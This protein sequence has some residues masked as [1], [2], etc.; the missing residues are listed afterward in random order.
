MKTEQQPGLPEQ[1]EPK[2]RRRRALLF[3]GL[4][5][6]VAVVILA[7]LFHRY[8][9]RKVFAILSQIQ[10]GYLLLAWGFG[11][12]AMFTFAHMQTRIFHPLQCGINTRL[13]LK[14]QYQQRFYALF[15]PGGTAAVVKWYKL[16]RPSGKPGLTLALMAFMRVLNFGSIAA[17]TA[18]AVLAD[19][20]FPW[21]RMR[22]IFPLIACVLTALPVWVLTPSAA[23]FRRRLWA[24]IHLPRRMRDRTEQLAEYPQAFQSLSRG[25][26]AH[27]YVH[28]AVSQVCYI[29]QQAFCAYAVGLNLHWFSFGWLRTLVAVSSNLPITIGGLGLREVSLVAFLGYY[30]IN[31]EQAIA[32]SLLFF[33]AFPFLRGI[34][35]G[36]SEL[37]DLWRSRP[38]RD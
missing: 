36:L 19:A 13:L 6:V 34:I 23:G 38:D 15:L 29:L 24:L 4:K 2:P 11:F 35:G 12:L 8:D 33:F 14:I 20:S 22:W 21:P 17:I 7:W 9:L 25:D 32:Y 5:A 28:S 31:E 1:Q 3:H 10:I 26:L 18:L 16:A 30:E 27:V 37:W